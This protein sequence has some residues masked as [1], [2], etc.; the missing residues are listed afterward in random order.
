MGKSPGYNVGQGQK[1]SAREIES[2]SVNRDRS[3]INY[4]GILRQKKSR[5]DRVR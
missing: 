5:E 4:E 2:D 3:P 1:P